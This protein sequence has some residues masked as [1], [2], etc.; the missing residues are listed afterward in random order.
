[1]M[2]SLKQQA[3]IP[4]FLSR[5]EKFETYLSVDRVLT[6]DMQGDKLEQ[7]WPGITWQIMF[8]NGCYQL[9]YCCM[10]TLPVAIKHHSRVLL[11]FCITLSRL[12]VCF[13]TKGF[14]TTYKTIHETSQK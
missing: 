9:G 11:E 7:L 1:M 13:V 12:S 10:S 14:Y 5:N 3:V 6:L 8:G 4:S 2:A